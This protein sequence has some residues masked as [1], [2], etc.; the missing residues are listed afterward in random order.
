[1]DPLR[2]AI[3]V[4]PLSA[5]LIV[6]G[7]VNT[8]RRVLMA[9][10]SAELGATLLAISGL[11]FVGPIELFRPEPATQD[12]GDAVWLL[13]LGLY[14]L[15]TILVVL[16]CRP[17]LIFYNTTP[18]QLRPLVADAVAQI[19]ADARWAGDS[20]SLPRLGVQLHLDAFGLLRTAALRSSGGEQ[21]LDGWRRLQKALS[22]SLASAGSRPNAR[23]YLLMAIGAALLVGS[24]FVLGAS[25]IEAATAI[26][27]LFAI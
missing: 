4:V 3:A 20:L 14:W 25:P 13:L 7:V 12:L 5:F 6:M 19:D 21:N 24:I 9:S 8:R 1:M 16:S 27:E 11:V 15:S 26:D 22:R 18:E 17:S 2:F 23:G 10:G